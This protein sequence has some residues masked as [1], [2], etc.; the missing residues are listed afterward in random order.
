[1]ADQAMGNQ[2]GVE[3]HW[4][5]DQSPVCVICKRVAS[6]MSICIPASPSSLPSLVQN[7]A[8]KNFQKCMT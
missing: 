3:D 1:M 2:N 7:L 6:Q 5:E 4:V 8:I